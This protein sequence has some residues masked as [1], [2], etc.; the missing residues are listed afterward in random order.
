MSLRTSLAR[1]VRGL[2]DEPSTPT[3]SGPPTSSPTSTP[4]TT[5]PPTTT[6]PVTSEAGV[7]G[8][9]LETMERMQRENLREIRGMVTDILQGREQEVGPSSVTAVNPSASMMSFDPPD[10]DSPD[11]TDLPGGI[12]AII[13]REEQETH[14]VR[15]LRTEQE[16]LSAQLDAARAQLMDPQGPAFV[17]SS[18]TD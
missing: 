12:Q 10:Y 2:L 6:T 3:T 17:P 11:L 18:S 15:L 9:V 4:P 1:Y 13:G 16:V 5:T 7:L 8:V 14:D